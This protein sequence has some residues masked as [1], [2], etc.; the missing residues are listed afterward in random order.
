MGKKKKKKVRGKKSSICKGIGK[1]NRSRVKTQKMTAKKVDKIQQKPI[2]LKKR[3]G[4][5]KQLKRTTLMPQ[6]ITNND[7]K[8]KQIFNS[9]KKK[10]NFFPEK[11]KEQCK[12]ENKKE[13]VQNTISTSDV[14]QKDK[15]KHH[16]SWNVSSN[17]VKQ[18]KKERAERKAKRQAAFKYKI[19]MEQRRLK[20][21]RGKSMKSPEGKK[22]KVLSIPK[23]DKQ[24]DPLHEFLKQ[25]RKKKNKADV[26]VVVKVPNKQVKD[27]KNSFTSQIHFPICYS[28][29][30]DSEN[31]L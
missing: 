4:L 11:E 27:I 24:Q 30:K 19:K 3:Y 14:Q 18:Y 21:I 17:K 22:S 28:K 8:V 16:F 2:T 1:I 13:N 5:S 31:L 26:E 12:K 25:K 6:K 20:D 7:K 9:N 23:K 15:K 29:K 10:S